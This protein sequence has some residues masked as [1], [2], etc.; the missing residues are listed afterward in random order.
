MK[1]KVIKHYVVGYLAVLSLFVSTVAACACS[2]H[3]KTKVEEPSCHQSSHTAEHQNSQGKDEAQNAHNV[4]L[5]VSCVCFTSSAPKAFG[6]TETIKIQKQVAVFATEVEVV[7]GFVLARAPSARQ[8]G[9][10][11]TYLDDSYNL[12]SPRAPPRL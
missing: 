10:S 12:K 5:D 4:A 1:N 9:F 7:Y 3:I 6:K 11:A 8:F 2:H